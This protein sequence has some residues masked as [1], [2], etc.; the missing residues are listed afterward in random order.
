MTSV[1]F[2]PELDQRAML[3]WLSAELKAQTPQAVGS[4]C[5]CTTCSMMHSTHLFQLFIRSELHCTAFC[6][7]KIGN[8]GLFIRSM[9]IPVRNDPQ[10]INP[11]PSHEPS[12]PFF[13]PHADQAIP[14]AI[15]RCIR[16]F[17]LYLP[18]NKL[19][20]RTS[21]ERNNALNDLQPL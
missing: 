5:N 18:T 11:I 6:T 12:K 3:L 2:P 16:A 17:W 7:K 10:T 1:P 13:S 19:E 20:T 8:R 9:N 14:N 4:Y 15:V 21:P